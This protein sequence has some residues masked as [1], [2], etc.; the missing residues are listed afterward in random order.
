MT[1]FGRRMS[2]TGKGKA[3]SLCHCVTEQNDGGETPFSSQLDTTDTKRNMKEKYSW[4]SLF[5]IVPLCER[6]QESGIWQVNWK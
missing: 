5:E 1:K 2:E 6:V 3:L 4:N